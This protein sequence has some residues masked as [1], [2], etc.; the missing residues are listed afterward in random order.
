MMKSFDYIPLQ[1]SRPLFWNVRK[2]ECEGQELES[3]HFGRI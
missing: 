1:S 2:E 3:N